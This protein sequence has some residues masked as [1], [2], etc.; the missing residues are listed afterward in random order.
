MSYRTLLATLI[1]LATIGFVVGV[2][3]E[4]TDE[5]HETP[6]AAASESGEASGHHSD[7]GEAGHATEAGSEEGPSEYKP[8]GLDLES[9]P[10]IILA[11][12]GS[13]G[14]AALTW[15][16]PRWLFGLGLAFLAMAAFGALDTAEVSHQAD[17]DELGLAVLAGFVAVLH[18]AAGF[19][20]L[21]MA[22][23]VRG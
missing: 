8:L 1:A 14:L 15:A 20:A 16:R 10:L 4:G 3:I 22:Q 23:A 19:V 5:H 17:I 11:A 2:S 12:L 6:A 13:L 7:E 9:T 18:F 21:R